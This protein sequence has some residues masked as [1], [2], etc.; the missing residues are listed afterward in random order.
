MAKKVAIVTGADGGMGRVLVRELTNAGY[1][2]IMACQDKKKTK[3]VCDAIQADTASNIDLFQ[4]DLASIHSIHQFVAEVTE[5]YPKIDLLLNNAGILPAKPEVTED[6]YEMTAGVN[7]LGPYTLT[8]SLLPFFTKGT[9]IINM[10]SLSYKWFKLSPK[11]LQPLTEKEYHQLVTYSNS[12]RGLVYFMLDKSEEWKK[13]EIA[14]HCADP[15]IVNTNIIKMGNKTIDRLCDI[16]FRP[17]IHSP[18]KGV[19]TMLW[20]ATSP[21]VEGETGGYYVKKKRRKVPTR[22]ANSP[23]RQW[24][25]ELTLSIIEKHKSA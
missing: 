8:T 24:L 17:L 4:L 20:L 11:F 3:P 7:Y 19:E 18:E 16:F 21:D 10:A 13:K 25:R 22:I 23:Q 9:R 1:K 15:G 2:V 6:G 12:K 14:I 5:I